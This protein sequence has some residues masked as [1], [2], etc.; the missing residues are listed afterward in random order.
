MKKIIFILAFVFSLFF[1][2]SS[3]VIAQ[4]GWQFSSLNSNFYSVYFIN[5]NTG[6]VVGDGSVILKTTNSGV[7]WLPQKTGFDLQLKSV[8]FINEYT[9]WLCGADGPQSAGG[10][11]FKTTNS[12]NNW[13]LMIINDSNNYNS[14]FFATNLTGWVCGADKLIIKS[15]NGGINWYQQ[16]TGI[17]Y[18]LNTI[19]FINSNTGWTGGETSALLKTTDSGLNWQNETV[20]FSNHIFSINF[21]DSDMGFY[22]GMYGT[23]KTTN[24]GN[25][26]FN[27]PGYDDA[28]S[29]FF[30]NTLIGYEC[31]MNGNI[32]KTVNGGYNWSM[33]YSPSLNSYLSSIYFLN[34][35]TGFSVGNC[36][37]IN[38]TTNGGD[39]WITNRYGLIDPTRGYFYKMSFINP[40]TGWTVSNIPYVIKTTNGG[41]NWFQLPQ[42]IGSYN[43]VFFVDNNTGWIG[44]SNPLRKTTDGGYNWTTQ[45]TTNSI[46]TIFFI[47]SQTGYTGG[48]GT[49]ILKTTNSGLNWI[50]L[51]SAPAS[52]DYL[53]SYFINQDIGW[54]VGWK[55]TIGNRSFIIKTTNGGSSFDIQQ[56]N[57]NSILRDV[58]FININTG[59][60]VGDSGLIIKTTN[61]GLNWIQ[62]SLNTRTKLLGIYFATQDTIYACGD[63]GIIVKSI[64]LGESWTMQYTDFSFPLYSIYFS[65]GKKGVISGKYC[66]ILT[67]TTGG[68]TFVNKFSENIPIRYSLHQNYPNPF[69]P[70]TKIRF[71]FPLSKGG[72]KGVVSLKVYDILGKEIQTLVNE[73]LQP[74]TYEVTFDCSNLPSGVYFYQLKAGEYTE[75]KKMLMIK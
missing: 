1:S 33:V 4:S 45:S 66:L 69:N 68:S 67:T 43:T 62:K 30:P 54:L 11:I 5:T 60:A 9:G 15:T 19:Y 24:G 50:N 75:T 2:H 61:S 41:L 49:N 51:L 63:S 7:S 6:W 42:M 8:Y 47:N 55:D 35:N 26:W 32:Y 46:N 16:L 28:K 39:N 73:Q 22:C 31:T 58:K 3:L 38:K 71:E 27:I 36:G 72:L 37:L 23:S 44:G 70:T 74:G 53:S 52:S 12:G 48:H 57:F 29:I 10:T 56:N 64:N 25:N 14:I 13:S 40:M 17:N 20:S 34:N 65:N 21:L 59:I 18:N